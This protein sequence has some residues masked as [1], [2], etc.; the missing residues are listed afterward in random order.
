MDRIMRTYQHDTDADF[1]Q[2]SL[3][4][5]YTTV[6]VVLKHGDKYNQKYEKYAITSANI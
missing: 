1:Q 5:L 2:V 4:K 6:H 3:A